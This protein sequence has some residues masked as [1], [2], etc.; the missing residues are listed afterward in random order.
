MSI[1]QEPWFWPTVLVVVGLPIAIVILSE[2]IVMLDRRGSRAVGVLTL[3]RNWVLPTGAL[4]ILLWQVEDPELELSWGRIVATVFGF[5]VILVLVNGINHLMF[6]RAAKGTWRE[7]IPSIFVDIARVVVVVVGIGLLMS[8]VWDADVAGLFTALGVTSIIVGLALQHAVGGVISGLLL[9]FE[10][11]FEQGE[12]IDT[13]D[14]R[15]RVVEVNWRS[16]HLETGDGLRIVPNAVLADAP[17]TNLSRT[18]GPQFAEA[19]VEFDPSDPPND[20][21]RLLVATAADLPDRPADAVPEATTDGAGA[22][23]VAIPVH[24]PG[25]RSGAVELFR[26]RLWY[27]AR[28]AG[29][30]QSGVPPVDEGAAADVAAALRGEASVL[31]LDPTQAEALGGSARLERYAAGE[32]IQ[33][34]GVVPDAVRI[35][36]EGR[37]VMRAAPEGDSGA[38]ALFELGRHDP[39]GLT[40]IMRRPIDA[41]AA[42]LTD[43]TMLVI[44]GDVA[45]GLVHDDPDLAREFGEELE[46]RMR[47]ARTAFAGAGVE[48]PIAL[49]VA[50]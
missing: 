30:T 25:E 10:Q 14:V 22:Y 32:T 12:W 41:S 24:S 43:A 42:A 26:T 34:H 38:L 5:V 45:A 3:V 39:I 11:P 18:P 48:A 1:V 35:V 37:V 33:A 16:V 23:R 13:G 19:T 15:G 21:K 40:A 46:L 6:T 47:R 2:A 20:V 9:L 50:G 29:L 31:N 36:V 49:R 4:L 28:R 44:P 8:W 7:R 17:F 27:A